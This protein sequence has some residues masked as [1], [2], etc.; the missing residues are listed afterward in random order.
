MKLNCGVKAG[1]DEGT[2]QLVK[3]LS[4]K[5]DDLIRSSETLHTA[6]CG[7]MCLLSW[8]WVVE[9]GTDGEMSGS[10]RNS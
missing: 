5:S 10:A 2:A 1:C 3:H 7:D 6:R 4:P 9:G 8:C